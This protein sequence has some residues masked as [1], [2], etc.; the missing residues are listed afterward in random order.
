MGW[1][2]AI[3]MTL[4]PLAGFASLALA[5]PAPEVPAADASASASVSASAPVSAS[6]AVSAPI[7]SAAPMI[8]QPPPTAT[9]VP[10]AA[11]PAS[12]T[13]PATPVGPPTLPPEE[14]T[15]WATTLGYVLLGIG[16]TEGALFG[17]LA[18]AALGVSGGADCTHVLDDRN[19]CSDA[20]LEDMSQAR[21]LAEAA[22]WLGITGIVVLG[23]S[24]LSLALA[25]GAK[26]SA[27]VSSIV[28]VPV[29]LDGGAA[30]VVGGSL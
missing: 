11:L 9:F 4:T 19:I 20:G 22:Q 16:L 25:P 13:L 15:H 3:V 28:V 8:P 18:G 24:I 30:V 7:P 17:A 21:G 1:A 12:T 23:G 6:A 2:R 26:V 29:P 10:G 5:Q 14:E 27:S